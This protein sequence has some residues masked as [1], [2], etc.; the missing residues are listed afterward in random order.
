MPARE[1][2]KYDLSAIYELIPELSD[3]GIEF[4]IDKI[5][6]AEIVRVI[7]NNPGKTRRILYEISRHRYNDDLY[8]KLKGYNDLTAFVYKGK[9]NIR[10]YCKEFRNGKKKIVAVLAVHK[11]SYNI[12]KNLKSK[13]DL[14]SKYQYILP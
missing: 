13:L 9:E 6:Y 10:I 8:E 11:K 14:I 4:Y 12:K 2:F 5:N 7:E 3:A 1:S